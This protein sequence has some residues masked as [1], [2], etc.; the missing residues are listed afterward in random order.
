MMEEDDAFYPSNILP[1]ISIEN[2]VDVKT[3]SLSYNY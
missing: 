1:L 3:N 2:K